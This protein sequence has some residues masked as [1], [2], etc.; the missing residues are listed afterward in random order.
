SMTHDYPSAEGEWRALRGLQERKV[1]V[2]QALLAHGADINARTTKNPPRVGVNMF[3]IVKMVG[4]TPVWIAAMSHDVEMMRL[5]A[6]HGADPMIASAD[7]VTPLMAASG[8]GRVEGDS[9]LT[10]EESV[11]AARLCLELGNDI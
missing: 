8:L 10:D 9:L 2:V 3:S 5:L 6:S 4:V 1:E 7:N 11:P